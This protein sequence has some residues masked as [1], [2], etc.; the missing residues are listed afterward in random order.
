MNGK[1]S[2]RISWKLFVSFINRRKRKKR[3]RVKLANLLLEIYIF[4]LFIAHLQIIMIEV[5]LMFSSTL[6]QNFLT[7]SL[8][9]LDKMYPVSGN[10]VSVSSTQSVLQDTKPKDLVGNMKKWDWLKRG[11]ATSSSASNENESG[12]FSE[13]PPP[14]KGRHGN[15]PYWNQSNTYSFSYFWLLL[16]I[17]LIVNQSCF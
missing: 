8:K 9:H 17:I 1:K 6:L 16:F 10:N 12:L 7:E 11:T 5:L 14:K 3:K 2:Q 13:A 15:W 4:Q